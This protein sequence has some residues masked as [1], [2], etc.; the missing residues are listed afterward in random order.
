[1][2][3]EFFSIPGTIFTIDKNVTSIYS[4][5]WLKHYLMKIILSIT[6]ATYILV[7]LRFASYAIVWSNTVGDTGRALHSPGEAGKGGEEH[8]PSP[9]TRLQDLAL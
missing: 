3:L 8:V 2:S 5:V 6:R 1:M 4:F 9:R 7:R